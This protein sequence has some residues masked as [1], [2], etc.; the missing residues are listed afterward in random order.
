MI[1]LVMLIFN[2][3]SYEHE[4]LWNAGRLTRAFGK[5]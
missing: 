4:L 5:L 2:R 3:I 1:L